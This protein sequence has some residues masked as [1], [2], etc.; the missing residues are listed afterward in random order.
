MLSDVADDHSYTF[1]K[2]NVPLTIENGVLKLDQYQNSAII[3]KEGQDK[4]KVK[5]INT[6]VAYYYMYMGTCKIC[7]I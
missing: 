3:L 1:I 4:G 2:I 6:Y 7:Y 5:Y